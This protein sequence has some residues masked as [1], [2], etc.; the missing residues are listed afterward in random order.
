M[1]SSNL[2]HGIDW[3][4]Q[5]LA[6]WWMSEKLDGCRLYWDGR[7][8]WT[9]GGRVVR[10]PDHWRLPAM[11]LDGELYDGPGGVYRCG[12]A[13]RYGRF[14]TSMR[15]C[16]FDAP[17]VAGDW[18]ERMAAAVAVLAGN[19]QAQA[20]AFR[21]VTS[22]ADALAELAAV[23]SRGG[24]GLMLCAPGLRYAAGRTDRLLKLKT[25]D[26]IPYP[27]PHLLPGLLRTA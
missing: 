14:A 3:T 6:G 23:K 16:V 18:S 24:E 19:A 15:F 12:A 11:A 4:G 8:A 9:R 1:N 10:L 21:R 2:Q 20:V 13:M 7:Q 5:D 22:T 26:P 27:M 25:P 17:Q